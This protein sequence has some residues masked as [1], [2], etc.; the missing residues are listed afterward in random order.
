MSRFKL[1]L[2]ISLTEKLVKLA[3]FCGI[4]RSKSIHLQMLTVTQA[5]Y[6][7]L[8][9]TMNLTKASTLHQAVYPATL[10]LVKSTDCL[11]CIFTRV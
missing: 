11:K 10:E 6:F 3:F 9:S 8:I 5:A 1:N 4:S 2:Q 7:Y